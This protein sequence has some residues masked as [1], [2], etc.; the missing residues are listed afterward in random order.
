[1]TNVVAVLCYLPQSTLNHNVMANLALLTVKLADEIC[2]H[3]KGDTE[4]FAEILEAIE[5]LKDH[6]MCPSVSPDPELDYI[7]DVI[8]SHLPE[9]Q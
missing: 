4:K 2:T 5:T 9:N 1:M 8:E 3:V 6:F 7:Q